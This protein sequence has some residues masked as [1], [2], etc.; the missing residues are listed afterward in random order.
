MI[1]GGFIWKG[2]PYILKKF[3]DT[4]NL[5]VNSLTSQQTLFKEELGNISHDFLKQVTESNAWHAT[6]NIRQEEHGKKIEEIIS[7][8]SQR[9]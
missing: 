6:F 4:T 8:I 9:K 7:I 1:V 5:F 2:V 3:D